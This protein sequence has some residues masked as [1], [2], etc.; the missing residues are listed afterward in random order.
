MIFSIIDWGSH[1]NFEAYRKVFEESG[2]TPGTYPVRK[3]MWDFKQPTRS[4][5]AVL[6]PARSA[7]AAREQEDE[8]MAEDTAATAE[9]PDASGGKGRHDP[10][11]ESDHDNDRN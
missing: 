2:V 11:S 10:D 5:R 6:R 1:S 9:D 3:D 8:P 7:P 4:W